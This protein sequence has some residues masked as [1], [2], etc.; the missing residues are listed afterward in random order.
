LGAQPVVIPAVQ[1]VLH[2]L[3][4]AHAK[5]LGHADDAPALQVPLPSQV[6]VGD[7]WALLH[8]GPHMVL[9]G[10]FAHPALPAPHLPLVPHE[11]APWSAHRVA[12]LQQMPPTQV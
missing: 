6:A 9:A 4:L 3:P 7:S 5:L 12:T 10:Y 2:M 8:T 11:T 1:V